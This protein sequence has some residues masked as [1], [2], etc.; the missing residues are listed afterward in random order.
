MRIIAITQ[1]RIGSTR[2]PNKILKKI[3]NKTILDIH[4]NRVLKS[5]RISKLIVATTFEEGVEQILEIANNNNVAYYQGDTNNVL[6]RYYQAASKE[7]PDFVVR[8]TSDCPLIDATLID[9]VI[10]YAVKND[11]D[12]CSNC[13]VENYPDGQDIEI[14]KF[15]AL[16]KTW[17]EAA[18][19]SEK[20]HVS[21]YI[22]KNST[23]KNNTM[24]KAKNYSNI[25]ENYKDIRLTVDEKPDFEVIK[26]LVDN[27]GVNA[28]WQEYT[29]YYIKHNV[30][31][32]N[33]NIIRNEGYLKSLK[34][35]KEIE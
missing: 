19:P 24:F 34:K 25:S 31:K 29:N 8:L 28:S 15:S 17:K 22:Y 14:F 1:A 35:D 20:E 12:Y 13:L 23:F 21:S 18:L 27:L 3:G 16:K 2:F 7:N 9:E 30:A 4:L 33:A 32:L 11:L 6:D 10:E 5:K 26:Q